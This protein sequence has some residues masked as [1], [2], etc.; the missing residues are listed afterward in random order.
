MSANNLTPLQNLQHQ[1]IRLQVKS[2]AL[3]AALE[4]NLEYLQQHIGSMTVDAVTS[5]VTSKMPFF[6]QNILGKRKE[7]NSHPRIGKMD[8]VIDQ[9]FDIIPFFVKGGKGLIAAFLLKKVKKL[10]FR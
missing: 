2:E 1:K 4:E 8:G 9:A 3:T 5:G 6:V 7:R 10:L